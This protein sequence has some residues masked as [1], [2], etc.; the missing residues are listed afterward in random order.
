MGRVTIRTASIAD[1]DVMADLWSTAIGARRAGLVPAFTV[2]RDE[3]D[4]HAE[5]LAAVSERLLGA[6]TI[7]VV[8]EEDDSPVAMAIA[9]PARADDG[10]GVELVPGLAHV[11][12]L[13]VRT[14]RWGEGLGQLVLHHVQTR[15]A[16]SGFTRAQ[17]WTQESNAR[18]RR[19]YE[20]LGWALS[21]R[22]KAD[23][24]GERICHYERPLR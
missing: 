4:E 22:T 20:R 19:L 6:D 13:A 14:D 21:T 8:A 1:A 17:L 12:M 23:E 16:A 24:H 3:D 7:A 11:S 18:G 15:A 2:V 9:L 5:A 10:A